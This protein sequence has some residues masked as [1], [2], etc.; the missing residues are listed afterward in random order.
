[1]ATNAFGSLGSAANVNKLVSA[2]GGKTVSESTLNKAAS[3][4]GTS[5]KT[6]TATNPYGQF[7]SLENLTKFV[8][9][10]QNVPDSDVATINKNL[11]SAGIQNFNYTPT[12]AIEAQ[13]IA[14][15]NNMTPIPFQPTPSPDADAFNSFAG[16]ALSTQDLVNQKSAEQTAW[17][18][19]IMKM[20]SEKNKLFSDFDLTD[21]F[22]DLQ[23]DY[24]VPELTKQL[25]QENLKLA[26]MQNNWKASNMALEQQAIP[27]PFVIG[28]QNELAKTAALEIGAQAAIVA[29]YQGNLELANHYVDKMID[30]EARD[31]EN[32]Y[33]AYQDNINLA[34]NFLDRA[35]KKQAQAIQYEL[36]IRKQ[37]HDQMLSVK[38]SSM[39]NALLNNAPA[40]VTQAIQKAQTTEE[41][42]SAAG[43]Y[44]VDPTAQLAMEGQRLSNRKSLL[45]LALMGDKSAINS[46]GYDPRAFTPE[47][48]EEKKKEELVYDNAVDAFDKTQ[49][50]LKNTLGL[51]A[52]SG[53]NWASQGIDRLWQGVKNITGFG[54]GETDRGKNILDLE[55]EFKANL[56]VLLEKDTLDALA[57]LPVKLT[58]MTDEDV[59]LVRRSANQLGSL[60]EW[61]KDKTQIVRV[62]GSVTEIER[63]IQESANA[64]SRII[65]TMNLENI[66]SSEIDEIL[67]L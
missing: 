22:Q 12:Q 6:T 11:R 8:N 38:E 29:A 13:N 45:E 61:N 28:Q 26:Q 20:N 27:Q 64:Y 56:G 42:Y 30:L 46:L 51:K 32:K 66:S 34:M 10:V 33:R 9:S 49:R 63:L 43:R 18:Q 44:A 3:G 1:M 41:V 17:E 67:N 48:L 53:Q 4:G 14:D 60:V 47:A 40:S 24:G 21:K 31:Y 58:P 23:K 59:A 15:M 5:S 65:D 37:E 57:N 62:K 35:D 2:L 25:Q 54:V 7:G 50:A 36:D 52:A 19:E 39:K 55:S 16:A